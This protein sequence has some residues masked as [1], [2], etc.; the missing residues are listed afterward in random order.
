MKGLMFV[1]FLAASCSVVQ[2]QEQRVEKDGLPL[3][4]HLEP[5]SELPQ[6]PKDDTKA[7]G[8][9][10]LIGGRTAD[11]KDWPAS[12]YAQ[13]NGARCT[14]TIVGERVLFIAAHCVASGGTATFR[15]GS[16]SYSSVCTHSKDYAANATAD[17]ALCQVDR[18]VEGVPYELVNQDARLVKV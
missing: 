3:M 17:Y 14:A 10:V 7:D 13:M 5:I 15:V 1:G 18:V 9:P 16:Q 2:K 6:D 11:P 4:I 12:M 8:K